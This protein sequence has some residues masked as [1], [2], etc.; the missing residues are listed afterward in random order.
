MADI[1]CEFSV[2][3]SVRGYHEYKD[4]WEAAIGEIL[5]CQR[6]LSN[7]HDPF[8]VAVRKNRTTVRHVPRKISAICLS[9]L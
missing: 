2:P 6:E 3:T 5:Q 4:I 9:L 1:E 7:R 8:A